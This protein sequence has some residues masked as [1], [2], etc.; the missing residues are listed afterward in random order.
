M[1]ILRRIWTD[2]R[3]RM[4]AF[5]AMLFVTPEHDRSVP[6]AL[7]NALDV[8]SWPYGQSSWSGKA[9]AIVTASPG[10]IGGFGA[11]HHLRQSLVFL[12][13]ATMAETE[14]DIGGAL[15]LSTADQNQAGAA[16]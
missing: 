2:F 14:G 11:N 4:R 15:K 6:A 1:P 13:V 9:G 12:N 7:K 5:N 8:G 10:G 16:A 3:Q